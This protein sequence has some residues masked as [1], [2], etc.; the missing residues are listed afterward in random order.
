MPTWAISA[1]ATCA[2]AAYPVDEDVVAA[3][4]AKRPEALH[5]R[6]ASR[7]T[8][9]LQN[10]RVIRLRH[11]EAKLR[12]TPDFALRFN[13]PAVRFDNALSDVKT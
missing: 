9:R 8:C 1:Y 11:G 10:R 13:T 5:P 7:A 12:A 4:F 3:V 6:Q 2:R